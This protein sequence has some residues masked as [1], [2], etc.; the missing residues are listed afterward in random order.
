[1]LWIYYTEKSWDNDGKA[2]AQKVLLR[3]VKEEN[4]ERLFSD[5]IEMNVFAMDF[6][7][8][9]KENPLS[10]PE[11]QRI[12]FEE[13]DKKDYFIE[14]LEIDKTQ[15]YMMHRIALFLKT[16]YFNETQLLEW[17]NTCL[18]ILGLEFTKWEKGDIASFPETNT[19][20]NMFSMDNVKRF[21]DKLGKDWWKDDDKSPT[22]N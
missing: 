20:W 12:Y 17:M 10:T 2:P 22:N 1:M 8:Q 11:Y 6:Y 18:S 15:G 3:A 14:E 9:L 13:L 16:D 19:L 4:G 5:I 7:F 21:E